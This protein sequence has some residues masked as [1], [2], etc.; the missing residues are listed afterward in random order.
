LLLLGPPAVGP[1]AVGGAEDD[2]GGGGGER[3]EQGSMALV[4]IKVSGSKVSCLEGEAVRRGLSL[5]AAA[6]A[7]AVVMSFAA[8][9]DDDDGGKALVDA[10][11]ALQV[12]MLG[13]WFLCVSGGVMLG[14]EHW[15]RKRVGCGGV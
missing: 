13:E 2:G 4:S 15:E 1:A 11:R 12:K 7:A 14:V 8:Q 10:L 6:A 3:R 9:P 5:M